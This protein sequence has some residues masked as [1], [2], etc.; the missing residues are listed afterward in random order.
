MLYKGVA[1]SKLIFLKY[2]KYLVKSTGKKLF[3]TY[4]KGR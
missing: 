3:I 2:L 1:D 4:I